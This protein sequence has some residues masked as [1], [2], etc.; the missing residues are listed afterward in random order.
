M[1]EAFLIRW[2]GNAIGALKA[3]P[4]QVWVIS[5]LV[6]AIPVNGC[7]QHG[8]GYDAGREA[9][10]S[11]LRAKAA[12]AKEKARDAEKQADA[13]ADERAQEFETQQEVLNDAIEEAETSGANA[14]DTIF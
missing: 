9:V 13:K 7:V 8:R 10:L 11:D 4:W 6:A 1:I 5:A 14:L 3:I 12:E 2:A